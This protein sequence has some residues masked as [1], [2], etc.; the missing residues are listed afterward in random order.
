MR[1]LRCAAGALSFGLLLVW[2]A[3]VAL[4][5]LALGVAPAAR[6]WPARRLQLVSAWARI[7]CRVV[8]VFLRVGGA[9]CTRVGSVDTSGAGL[10]VTNHQSVL[11]IPTLVLMSR[12]F[13]P[14]FVAR[15]RYARPGVPII[16]LGLRLAGCPVIDPDD[17]HASVAVL[18]EAVRRDRTLLIYPEG[19]RSADGEL[20]RFRPAGLVA[21]LDERRVPVWLVATDGF[22]AGRRLVDFVLNVHRIDGCTE[23]V[24][25]YD[26]P[27]RTEELPAFVARLHADLGAHLVT[28]RARRGGRPSSD[29]GSPLPVT[30]LAAGSVTP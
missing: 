22:S 17:R 30:A 26:P 5:S 20:Q 10:V 3:L 29:T 28:M 25:R 21:M 18:R 16:P 4:P 14:A 23:V 2:L 6:L 7:V 27:A 12:P 11:D 24:G 15:D 13:V 8:L 9:R 1:P 19:R